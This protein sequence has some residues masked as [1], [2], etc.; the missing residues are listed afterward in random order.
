MSAPQE[1]LTGMWTD[2]NGTPRQVLANA[3][4]PYEEVWRTQWPDGRE[5]FSSGSFIRLNWT[6]FSVATDGAK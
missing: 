6:R 4:W 5:G 2:T 3:G 1:D